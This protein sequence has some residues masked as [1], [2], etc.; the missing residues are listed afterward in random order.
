[1]WRP[2]LLS[3][4]MKEKQP[5]LHVEG[6][7]LQRGRDEDLFLKWVAAFPFNIILFGF[8]DKGVPNPQWGRRSSTDRKLNCNLF[9][10]SEQKYKMS[11]G[12]QSHTKLHPFP[13]QCLEHIV[14]KPTSSLL[15]NQCWSKPA[16]CVF[17]ERRAHAMRRHTSFFKTPR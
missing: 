8:V 17:L 11:S 4:D 7:K 12:N 10:S 9:I 14:W 3:T 6:V 15:P 5:L 1:M 13:F 2:H 16:P